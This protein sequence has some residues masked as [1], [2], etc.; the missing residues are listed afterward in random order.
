MK[1]I[2]NWE[3]KENPTGETYR[4]LIKILCDH[5][6]KFYFITRK[7]LNYNKNII[8]LFVPYILEVFQ[9]KE[10]ANTKTLGPPANVYMVS[11]NEA[12][13]QLLQQL[14]NTLYD[15]VSPHLPEDLTFIKNNFPWFTSTTHEQFAQF[16]IRSQY[17]K[18]IICEQ[19][20][21][22]IERIS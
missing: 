16:S 12:T 14:A 11:A 5:S 4:Q 2:E 22:K 19:S 7:E 18:N 17:Y 15:W 20:N 10:W 13:C 6:D 21:L 1:E 8:Q 3:L 9:T